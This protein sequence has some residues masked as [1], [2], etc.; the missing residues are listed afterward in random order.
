MNQKVA[1]GYGKFNSFGNDHHR[2]PCEAFDRSD[3]ARAPALC[4]GDDPEFR[5]YALVDPGLSIFVICFENI[6]RHQGLLATQAEEA[7]QAQSN[8]KAR[9]AQIF[10]S[11]NNGEKL[12]VRNGQLRAFSRTRL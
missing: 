3:H 6:T 12:L 11:A 2:I 10:S 8:R 4:A 7:L 9:M 5:R 1:I